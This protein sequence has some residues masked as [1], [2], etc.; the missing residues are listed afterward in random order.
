VIGDPLRALA[1]TG[2]REDATALAMRGVA[3]AQLDEPTAAR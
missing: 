1:A 3:L 2:G